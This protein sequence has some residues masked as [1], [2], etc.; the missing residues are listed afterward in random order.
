MRSHQ[1]FRDAWVE[2][3]LKQV[4][5]HWVRVT[6]SHARFVLPSSGGQR[7]MAG[8]RPPAEGSQGMRNLQLGSQQV[9]R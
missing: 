5:N 9:S 7:K 6:L 3:G 8:T 4:G 2:H 1:E